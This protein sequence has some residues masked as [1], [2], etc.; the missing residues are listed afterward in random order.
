MLYFP[1]TLAFYFNTLPNGEKVDF[2]L[3]IFFIAVGMIK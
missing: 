2:N 1:G 3:N